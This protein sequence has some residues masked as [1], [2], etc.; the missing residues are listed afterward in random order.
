MNLRSTNKVKVE[1]GMS[2]MTDLVFLLLIFFI[3]L[4]TKVTSGHDID[5]PSSKSSNTKEK[6][7]IKVYVTNENEYFIGAKSKQAVPQEELETAIMAE[8]K[9]DSVIELMGDKLSSWE[10][11]VK[12][13]DIA[14][15]NRLAVVI[16]TKAN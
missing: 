4:S 16:K 14:K 6:S 12:V 13:I 7:N 3:V 2:S 10:H 8:L 9:N 11:S 5:L 1:G 15:R